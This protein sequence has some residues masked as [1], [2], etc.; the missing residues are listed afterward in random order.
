[1]PSVVSPLLPAYLGVDVG[2]TSIKIGIVDDAGRSLAHGKIATEHEKGAADGVARILEFS[3]GL[4]GE[5]GVNWEDVRAIGLGTPGTMDVKEGKLLHMPN[6][7]GWDFFPIRSYLENESG[8]PVAFVNDGNAAAYGEYWV[9]RGSEHDSVVMITLGTGVG[10]GIIMHDIALHGDNSHGSECG[11]I[12]IDSGPD[13]RICPCG[14]PGHLEAY[15]S[16]TS[17]VK[18]V[19]EKLRAGEVSSLSSLLTEGGSLTTLDIANHGEQ[20]DEL[21]RASIIETAVLL[22]R[23]ITSIMHIIDPGIVVLGGGMNF[24]GSESE[25]GKIFLETIRQTVTE[26]TFPVLAENTIIDF[27]TLGSSC[28][29]IGA[30]GVARKYFGTTS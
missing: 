18:R 16:A 14:Q 29:Y 7:S 6:M 20:G 11:H 15:V 10:G 23:G 4:L 12:V 8:K 19:Q 21:A 25:M 27:A 17:L 28:G 26:L 30:A 24:G 5:A 13:A 2:G 3:S 22:G 9:G 1:M